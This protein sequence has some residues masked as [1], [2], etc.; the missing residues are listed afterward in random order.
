M[1]RKAKATGSRVDVL[2]KVRKFTTSTMA[3]YMYRLGVHRL[4]VSSHRSHLLPGFKGG[5]GACT[6]HTYWNSTTPN[7]DKN[8]RGALL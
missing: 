3:D 5:L 7:L 8:E 2:S 4:P 6:V 1:S